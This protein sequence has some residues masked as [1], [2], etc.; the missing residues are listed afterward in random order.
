MS[1]AEK[2]KGLE[3][4]HIVPN[5]EQVVWLANRQFIISK[6]SLF[7]RTMFFDRYMVSIYVDFR[8]NIRAMR[9][10]HNEDD[11]PDRPRIYIYVNMS[12]AERERLWQQ[13]LQSISKIVDDLDSSEM[14]TLRSRF[15]SDI[16]K[17]RCIELEECKTE[18]HNCEINCDGQVFHMLDSATKFFAQPV[19]EKIEKGLVQ[20]QIR[21]DAM[22][23]QV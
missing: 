14:E 15:M 8:L 1:L 2:K 11:V 4:I 9:A 10:V 7:R 20:G 21:L 18:C 19:M 5:L 17:G 12:Y 6:P 3:Y 16:D 23:Q 22:E 13:K